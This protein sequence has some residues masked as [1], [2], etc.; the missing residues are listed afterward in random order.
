MAPRAH[1]VSD[2]QGSSGYPWLQPVA[3]K[4]NGRY[5]ITADGITEVVGWDDGVKTL[6]SAET[7]HLAL[8][9]L[10]AR[11][12]GVALE[13]MRPTYFCINEWRH[14]LVKKGRTTCFAGRWDQP[15]R[16]VRDG[17]PFGPEAPRGLPPGEV[18][19]HSRVGMRYK[20]T[21][22]GRDVHGRQRGPDG[23]ERIE[24]LSAYVPGTD[25]W[26]TTW[27]RHKPG[28]GVVYINEARELF[29]PVGDFYVYFGYVPL[30]MWF[31]E[32]EVEN[33]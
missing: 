19:P 13:D 2:E 1:P 9:A 32:P 12:S 4:S 25:A 11:A 18:W 5:R 16:F 30:D 14:V 10:V 31:S 29:G 24:R 20:L 8:A 17:E 27:S 7:A 6:A 15:L 3:P 28:G 26:V 21:A 33:E 23:V 22:S